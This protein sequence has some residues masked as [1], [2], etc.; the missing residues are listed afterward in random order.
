M[1]SVTRA[2]RSAIDIR[3]VLL[4]VATG[5]V[6]LLGTGLAAQTLPVP[7]LP[8][9]A[10]PAPGPVGE[11]QPAPTPKTPTQEPVTPPTAD[12]GPA[13]PRPWE[14]TLG[15]GVAWD[16][17]TDFLLPDGASST[18]IVPSGRIARVLSNPHGQLRAEAG[19]RWA[20]YPSQ[21]TI[22]RS[23]FDGGLRGEYKP[24]PRS[25]WRG[26]V[27]YWLGYTDYSPPP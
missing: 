5:V 3:S 15:A 23:Y 4:P 10:S 13:A 18:A 7:S 26:E 12:T 14:F 27:H 2:R 9:P 8:P 6:F 24:S 11:P 21:D 17:N 20:A 1:S 19:G 22:N 16:S 25:E